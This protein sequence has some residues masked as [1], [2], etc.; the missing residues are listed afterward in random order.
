MTKLLEQL[1]A[2]PEVE[3]AYKKGRSDERR[4]HKCPPVL[5]KFTRIVYRA[6]KPHARSRRLK[7]GIVSNRQLLS[8]TY[9]T[10]HE[11][12]QGLLGLL[13]ANPAALGKTK[14]DAMVVKL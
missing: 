13:P 14:I 6:R 3:E 2:S 9:A 10:R 12:E 1:Y 5:A 4:D 8:T 11:A 7:Y